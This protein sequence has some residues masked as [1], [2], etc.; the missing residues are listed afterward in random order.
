MKK[1]FALLVPCLFVFFGCYF[2]SG[3][4]II[5]DKVVYVNNSAI[6]PDSNLEFFLYFERPDLSIRQPENEVG[7]SISDLPLALQPRAVQVNGNDCDSLYF[8]HKCTLVLSEKDSEKSVLNPTIKVTFEDDFSYEQ[9]IDVPVPTT[10]EIPE[11]LEPASIS[12]NE[13]FKVKFKD[14]GADIY[15]VSVKINP[16]L[17]EATYTFTRDVEGFVYKFGDDKDLPSISLTKGDETTP[18]MILV[19]SDFTLSFEDS[20]E[21]YVKAIK[22]GQSAEGVDTYSETTASKVFEL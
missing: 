3:V 12:Q 14:V 4:G 19:E 10:F 16:Y 21:Y 15:E 7:I 1:I 13:K 8:P 18:D 5:I 20:V 9:V 17:N 6:S 11:I 22:T 2:V